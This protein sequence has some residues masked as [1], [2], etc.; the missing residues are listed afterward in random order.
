MSSTSSPN[1]YDDA[2]NFLVEITYSDGSKNSHG[3]S[4]THDLTIYGDLSHALERE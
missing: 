4:I 1:P 2:F 3:E